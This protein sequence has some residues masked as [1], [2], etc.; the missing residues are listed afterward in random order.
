MAETAKAN[1]DLENLIAST[2]IATVFVDRA[3]R[4][5]RYTAPALGLF[6]LIKSVVGRP[7]LDLTHRLKYPELAGDAAAVLSSQALAAAMSASSIWF[8]RTSECRRWMAT[9]LSKR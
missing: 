4:I 2:D 8:C 9:N 5:K 6:N 3:M 1:D 7:L